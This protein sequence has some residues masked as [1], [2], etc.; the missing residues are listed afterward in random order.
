MHRTSF[1][2]DPPTTRDSENKPMESETKKLQQRPSIRRILTI[3]TACFFVRDPCR[4]QLQ[5]SVVTWIPSGTAPPC[6]I[7]LIL[8]ATPKKMSKITLY[9]LALFFTEHQTEP[10]SKFRTVFTFHFCFFFC[11]SQTFLLSFRCIQLLSIVHPSSFSFSYILS[12]SFLFLPFLKS[13]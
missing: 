1:E 7:P 6:P 13:S 11:S 8:R 12:F 5:T 9:L 4:F 2:E 3:F 10:T